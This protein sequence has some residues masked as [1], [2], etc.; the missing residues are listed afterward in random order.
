MTSCDVGASPV[1]AFAIRGALEGAARISR[2]RY[3]AMGNCITPRKWSCPSRLRLNTRDLPGDRHKGKKVWTR[4]ASWHPSHPLTPGDAL[5]AGRAGARRLLQ[6]ASAGC[7]PPLGL[8]IPPLAGAMMARG[9]AA[10]PAVSRHGPSAPLP[11]P[12][13]TAATT[14][15]SR[16]RGWARAVAGA[17]V[18]ARG[19]SRNCHTPSDLVVNQWDGDVASSSPR[20][21][22]VLH[23]LW[24]TFGRIIRSHITSKISTG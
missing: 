7:F 17:G 14:G 10:P 6:G 1:A 22:L 11:W 13:Y 9:T 18:S 20:D 15:P 2:L 12:A 24:T 4:G 5:D 16:S 19:A 8:L 23:N 21:F 3:W